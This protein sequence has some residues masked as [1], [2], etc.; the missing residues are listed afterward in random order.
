M[1]VC[2]MLHLLFFVTLL[3]DFISPTRGS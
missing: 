1:Y 3:I 2:K